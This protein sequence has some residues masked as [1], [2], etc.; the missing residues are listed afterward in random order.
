MNKF[1]EDRV[2][3]AANIVLRDNKTV[4]ETGEELG[5]SRTTIHKDITV[6][7]AKLNIGM[8]NQV[9]KVLDTNKSESVLRAA[10]AKKSRKSKQKE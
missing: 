8:A 2:M 5:V 1:V 3:K 4:R 10:E 6:R 9:R 7:L